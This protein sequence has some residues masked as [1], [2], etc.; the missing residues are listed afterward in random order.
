MLR[1]I[2]F[3]AILLS[4]ACC[5][6]AYGQQT[7][8]DS[9]AF[10]ESK[11]RPLLIAQC[12]SCHGPEKQKGGLRLDSA[13]SLHKG[14]D[15]GPV[16]VPG[17]PEQ[18]PLIRAINYQADVKMPPKAKLRP[19]EI[20][21]LATWVKQ[22]AVWPEA[23]EKP[24]EF[25]VARKTFWAFQ[26]VRAVAP[27][28]VK[29]PVGGA[30]PRSPVDRFV[31]S[32]M[33]ARG[34]KPVAAADRRTLVRRATFDLTGL[35]PTPEELA[36]ALRDSSPDWFEKVVDRLLASSAYGE[37]Y[38]RHW[39]DLV[40]YA[41]TAG[42]NSDYPVPE[43]YRY[44]NWVIHAFN[45]DKPYDQFLREQ[46][47]GDLMPARDDADRN[48]KLIATGYLAN[49][50]RFGSERFIY[51]WHLTI[52]D[53]IDNL[54]RTMLGLTINCCR[55]HDHKFDPLTNHDYY[56]LY[57]FF[58]ST[59][60]PWPGIEDSKAPEDRTALFPRS[61][62][63]D[64]AEKERRAKL[65][66][67][68]AE[69][70][71]LEDAKA[72]RDA[73]KAVQKNRE[74]EALKPAAYDLAYAVVDGSPDARLAIMGRIGNARVQI[75]GDPKR[76][77]REVPRRFPTVLGGQL[78]SPDVR[79]SGRLELAHWITAPA[80]PMTAR[81]MVN[82]I[83]QYHFGK[84][85]VA[86]PSDFGKQGRPPT[87]PELLDYL[88]AQLIRSGWSIKS[89][90]RLIMLSQTYQL[91]SSDDA[92]NARIDVNNDYYWRGTRHRLDAESIRDSM[93]A[94]AGT[95]DR[96]MGGAHPFPNQTTW[97]FTQHTPFKAVYPTNRR[98]VYLM[99]QRIQRHPFLSLFDGADTNASTAQR[100][101]STTPLQALFL[102]NDPF[103]HE[104]ARRFAARLRG[105]KPDDGGRIDLAYRLAFGR[106]ATEEE[107]TTAR[108][109]LAKVQNKVRS[110]GA[111]PDDAAT[112][113]LESF[114][115]VVFM[116]NEFVY[117]N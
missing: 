61:E 115:R 109:Y 98:S 47:A 86:T 11:V 70:K 103:V 38:G 114:A 9:A 59:R 27:P 112:K 48:G 33:Q 22:G 57:G 67:F 15:S 10:F 20:A 78:L 79:G 108:D 35:P 36:A 105:E 43:M 99:T 26:P 25:E 21:D 71:R 69:I 106:P 56:A 83:W 81:V 66:A 64:R 91:S 80:N 23:G 102:M 55:C 68:D 50:R 97:N 7:A 54:G 8:S 6:L 5:P 51:P 52:E 85:I 31:L 1:S 28:S 89:M 53:T 87:H 63:T 18:S 82:R 74:R 84:G 45:D 101:T 100:I 24:S 37:R 42:D 3:G 88:A 95:L 62:A 34:L 107:Q 117:V 93:L 30:W 92:D 19:E 49:A 94:V 111:T 58:Q 41:D 4:L 113:A 46:L 90:H 40:R 32:T 39:L 16:V 14:S 104:Q 12:H 13:A 73:I 76:P 77:G 17:K 2:V 110:S 96:S 29:S 60:Y 65:D 44:R 116:S 75:K 72:N